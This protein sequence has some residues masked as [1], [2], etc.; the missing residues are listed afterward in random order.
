V[1]ETLRRHPLARAL[2]VDKLTLAALEATLRGPAPPTARALVADPDALRERAE[3]LAGLLGAAGVDAVA[4]AS[5]AAVGGGGAPGVPLPSAAVSLPAAYADRL[6]T[7]DPAVL[8]RVERGRCLLDLR[9]VEET[10]DAALRRA[11][12]AASSPVD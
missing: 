9:A 6:R 11:V 12:L 8:G 1:V 5:E 7:G 3:R 10:D 2:R 4:V